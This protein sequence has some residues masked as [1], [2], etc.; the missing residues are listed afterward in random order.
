MLP[1]VTV[2]FCAAFAELHRALFA[3]C[4]LS[5]GATGA[6]DARRTHL[7]H[8][9][10]CAQMVRQALAGI[11]G[12][13][14][15]PNVPSFAAQ[16]YRQV[17]AHV[18]SRL[19]L[20][21]PLSPTTALLAAIPGLHQPGLDAGV[22]EAAPTT[23]HAAST[24]T[25][26]TAPT[27]AAA[28]TQTEDALTAPPTTNAAAEQLAAELAEVREALQR[29]NSELAAASAE[30]ATLRTSLEALASKNATLEEAL[31]A[32][33]QASAAALP[34]VAPSPPVQPPSPAAFVAAAT[35]PA[36]E[37]AP[38][39]GQA[40]EQ[41]ED[42]RSILADVQSGGSLVAAAAALGRVLQPLQGGDAPDA[43]LVELVSTLCTSL[44]CK[45]GEWL[46]HVASEAEART[47]AAACLTAARAG[48]ACGPQAVKPL[49][50]T[51]DLVGGALRGHHSFAP[52]R[53]EERA[54]L[55]L[56]EDAAVRTARTVPVAPQPR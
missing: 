28:A 19:S 41:M 17:P 7:C 3:V 45:A 2:Y 48:K 18:A 25:A 43:M 8:A 54:P 13:Q 20:D 33:Q 1:C 50:D 23:T 24:Q 39:S 49:K 52:A 5:P 27:T 31:C 37:A 32:Q 9:Q 11:T 40:L 16:G 4:G 47:L 15:S 10:A 6:G 51:A 12:L 21:G 26:A 35:A 42:L 30:V 36:P 34:V 22:I 55:E 38:L 29:S 44:A 14:G 56:R 46:K 53:D